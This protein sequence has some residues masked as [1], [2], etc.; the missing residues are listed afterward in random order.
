M[1]INAH[2]HIS[3]Q[4]LNGHSVLRSSFCNAPFKVANITPGKKDHILKLMIMCSSPGILNEDNYHLRFEVEANAGLQLHTQSYQRL[5]GMAT[6]A[7]QHTDVIVGASASFCFLPHP[8]VP[9]R[10]ASFTAVNDI[11]LHATSSLLYGEVLTCGRKLNGE[12]FHYRKYHSCTTIFIADKIVIK[13]NLLIRPLHLNTT[14]PGQMEQY[15]HQASLIYIHPQVNIKEV[16]QRVREKLVPQERI[17]FGISKAPVNGF[18]LRILGHHAE[19]LF[20]LLK[21]VAGELPLGASNKTL[22]YAI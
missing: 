17:S 6:E 3:A 5:F 21:A 13:E 11:R 7:R 4:W 1:Q 15:T 19:Q 8:T 14:V 9:H 18:V 10:D 2:V 20:D 12:M 16:V 22:A